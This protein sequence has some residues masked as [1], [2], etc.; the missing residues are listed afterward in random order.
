MDAP[1][2]PDPSETDLAS[3]DAPHDEPV[4]EDGPIGTDIATIALLI[5]F[6]SLIGIVALMLLLPIL[7]G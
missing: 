5:F 1:P 6:I 7:T 3:P 2:P 4:A